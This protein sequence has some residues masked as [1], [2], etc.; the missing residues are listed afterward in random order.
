MNIILER[1][2]EIISAPI[3]NP[4]MFWELI[5]L[6]ITMII[7]ELYF[8]RYKNE[9]TGWAS[10]V[11]NSL[12]LFFVGSNLLH[13]LFLIEIFDINTLRSQLAIGVILLGLIFAIFDFFHILP[14]TI[15]FEIS[16]VLP[17]HTI[18]L[19]SI[20]L[21]HTEIILDTTTMQASILI[22]TTILILFRILQFF[23][24]KIT[25]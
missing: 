20:V 22:F 16:S 6:I 5:P 9:D 15:A 18:A 25:D 2:I 17:I 21:V 3:L 7:M 1:V 23:E 19:I 13:Y 8:G 4:I 11:S 14:K 10:T 12:I 24:T